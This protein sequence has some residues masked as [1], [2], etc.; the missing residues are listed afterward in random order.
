MVN[1]TMMIER[2]RERYLIM[3]I[4]PLIRMLVSQ[5]PQGAQT[6]MPSW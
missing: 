3:L 6:A 5:S 2:M 4:F 1:A